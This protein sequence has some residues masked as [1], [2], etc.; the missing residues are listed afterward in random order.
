MESQSMT[1][2]VI[3]VVAIAAAVVAWMYLQRQRTTRVRERFG[4]EYE[5]A[6]KET[7]TPNKAVAVLEERVRR[8]ERFKIHPLSPEQAQ[9]FAGD[10]QRV[11]AMFVDDPDGAVRNADRLVTEVM[12]A[13]GY[14]VEDFDTRAAD[15]SVDHPRVIENY[16]VARTLAL[17]RDRGEAG[18]EELR[19]AVVNYRQLFDDLLDTREDR[20]TPDRSTPRMEDHDTRRRAS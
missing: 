8:V 5:R 4:P 1:M 19:Q 20:K 6:V 12:T 18:T 7:G 10:W 16:R 11:Q 15:L 3:A 13:R 14:P 17:R 9:A 2:I